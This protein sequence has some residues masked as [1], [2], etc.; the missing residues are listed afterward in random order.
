MTGP[1]F[2]AAEHGRADSMEEYRDGIVEVFEGT[3]V[4]IDDGTRAMALRDERPSFT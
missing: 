4:P 1:D 2:Q 3:L